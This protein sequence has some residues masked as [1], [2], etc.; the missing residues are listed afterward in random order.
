MSIQIHTTMKEQQF[1][2]E[3]IPYETLEKFGISSTMVLDMPEPVR[4]NLLAGCHTPLVAVKA[5]TGY[6]DVSSFARLRL[7]RDEDG[8]ARLRVT[9]KQQ[10]RNYKHFSAEQNRDLNQGK[11]ILTTVNVLRQN[12][13]GET[14]EVKELSFVQKDLST[15]TLFVTPAEQL[16]KTI[17]NI[18]TVLDLDNDTV[19]GLMAGDEIK[20]LV[21]PD[22]P[23]S[24]IQTKVDLKSPTGLTYKDQEL[25]MGYGLEEEMEPDRQ[26][27]TFGTEGCWVNNKG[28]LSY[29]E[30]KD[31]TDDIKAAQRARGFINRPQAEE[32]RQQA[33]DHEEDI[34]EEERHEKD[35]HLIPKIR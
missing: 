13:D 6:G 20:T 27:Y 23:E 28:I 16:C 34:D 26:H 19:K 22:N 33:I 9:L 31:F 17:K 18:S 30:E 1:Y 10:S 12:H 5:K 4:E 25:T 3:E 35:Q 11:T 24:A 14:E 21:D 15:N 29:V 7:V 8:T 2:L 32:L